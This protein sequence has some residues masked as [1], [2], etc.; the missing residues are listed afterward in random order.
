MHVQDAAGNPLNNVGLSAIGPTN[1]AL[2]FGPATACGNSQYFYTRPGPGEPAPAFGV[3]DNAGNLTLWLFAT[4]AGDPDNYN[5]TATPLAD[6]GF[7]EATVSGVTLTAD[8]TLVIVLN[9][10]HAAP[11]TTLEISPARQRRR[12]LSRPGDH[13]AVGDGRGGL[14]GRRHLLRGRRHRP[15]EYAGPFEVT[16][17]GAHS[18]RYFSVDDDGVAETPKTFD[19]TIEPPDNTPPVTTATVSPDAERR[20]LA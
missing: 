9:A 13:H 16:G 19:F 6:S 3:T 14:R 10:T 20:R 18:I 1:C 4:P 15:A 17:G 12:H 5:L 8:A 11:V 2:V 7:A